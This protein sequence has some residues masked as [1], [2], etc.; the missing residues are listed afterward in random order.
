[1]TE[2]TTLAERYEGALSRIRGA[3]ASAGRNQDEL[4]LVVVTKNH[5]ASLVLE[6]LELGARDFGENR[7]QE[8]AP[9][10]AEVRAT[11]PIAHNWHFVGQLQSNKV[12][13]VL[14]YATVLHSLDRDSLL[15]ELIKQTERRE[16]SLDVFIELNLTN[17]AGRGGIL[18]E[19]LLQFA[20]KVLGAERL[21][22]LGVMG[23]AGL[24]ADPAAEFERIRAA[25][26]QLQ[27]MAPDARYISAGMSQDFELAIAHG[28][29]H[30]RIGTAI[31][32]K[33]QY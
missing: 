20:E 23:V 2:G 32:G 14:D 8:A 13:S 12:K 16:T 18:P 17:D 27:T 29:T 22:L 7:D 31:T 11:S 28:A 33:R 10:A 1:M 26:A 4:T 9:K 3:A 21:N 5:P 6:L 19:N 30:L 24:D 15:T 25:S